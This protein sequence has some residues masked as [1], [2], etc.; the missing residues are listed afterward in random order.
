MAAVRRLP[1]QRR[2]R[3][4]AGSEKLDAGFAP[5][6]WSAEVALQL[7]E[8]IAYLSATGE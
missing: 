8:G 7:D 6:A 1:G 4:A 3:A 5:P 2:W